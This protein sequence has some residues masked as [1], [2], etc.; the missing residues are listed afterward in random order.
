[1][2]VF[3][4]SLSATTP[5]S[6]LEHMR[7]ERTRSSPSRA[8]L[9]YGTLRVIAAIVLFTFAAGQSVLVARPAAA[10]VIQGTAVSRTNAALPDARVRLREA[11]R[12]RIVESVRCD[13]F[14]AFAFRDLEPGSYVAELLSPNDGAVV[15]SSPIIEVNAGQS[16]ATIVKEPAQ[17]PG[18][19]GILPVGLAIVSAAA[20]IGIL[21]TTTTGAP[22]TDRALPGQR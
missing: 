11:R 2:S 7:L 3:V 5:M 6:P 12:G 15:A 1:M 9:R 4:A 13:R 19:A 14:G 20:A 22:A 10:A 18:G 17:D 16:L 8:L 21:A